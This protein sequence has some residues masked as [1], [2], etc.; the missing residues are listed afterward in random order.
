MRFKV[1]GN[2]KVDGVE[3]GKTVDLDADDPRTVA[4]I[5]AG[6]LTAQPKPPTKLTTKGER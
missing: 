2:H 4:L 5:Q 3:P 6:H 1:T